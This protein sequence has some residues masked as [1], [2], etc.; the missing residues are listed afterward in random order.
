[1]LVGRPQGAKSGTQINKAFTNGEKARVVPH[2][3]KA[4]V[5]DKGHTHTVTDPGHVHGIDSVNSHSGVPPKTGFGTHLTSWLQEENPPDS[6]AKLAKTGVAVN[7]GTSGVQVSVHDAEGEGYPLAYVLLCRHDPKAE[8][9]A[10]KGK[11]N[12]AVV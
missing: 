12:E 2:G 1:M 9:A 6:M 10:S 8:T 11:A 5:Q 4:S 7:S 3:H